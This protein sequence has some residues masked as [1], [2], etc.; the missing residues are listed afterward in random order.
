MSAAWQPAAAQGGTQDDEASASAP[1]IGTLAGCA[2][3]G[4]S[5]PAAPKRIVSRRARLPVGVGPEPQTL[6]QIAPGV[7][8]VCALL[9]AMLSVNSLYAGD[10][11]DGT[12]EQLLLCGQPLAGIALAR[13]LSHWLLTGLPLV[14]VAPLFGLMFDLTPE[15]IGAH[16][17]TQ[18]RPH[19]A[20]FEL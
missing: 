18:R 17:V 4:P 12:L 2:V 9:A 7:V 1:L 3:T 14:I 15:G 19:E 10:H 8:W 5:K 11:A 16:G 6:R 20:V 13:S